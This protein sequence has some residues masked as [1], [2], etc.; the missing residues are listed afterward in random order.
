MFF[1]QLRN[2][3]WKLFGKKRT[4][5][6]FCMFLSAQL[7]LLV[8]F[9]YTNAQRWIV[10]NIRRA[11][12]D[13]DQYLSA[14]TV[15]SFMAAVLAL[16]LIPLYVTLV[17]GDLV[18]KEAEDGT[19]RMILSRPISR[20]RLVFL[21]WV[22]GCIFS[23]ALVLALGAFGLLFSSFWFPLKGGFFMLSIENGVSI[24]DAREGLQHYLL[25][26]AAMVPKACAVMSLAL[27]FSCFN[28]K[29]AAATILSLSLVLI[30][31][32]LRDIPYFA[33]FKHWFLSYYLNVWIELF[34]ARIAWWHVGECLSVM[35]AFSLTC[36]VIGITAFQV[37]DIKS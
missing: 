10:G 13:P 15:A 35:A 29:P 12:F 26:H 33:D 9:R 18:S 3:L 14:L 21:K 34:S 27:M 23:F 36:L 1:L 37:R 17:G 19:L 30:D 25:A 6:G 7:L 31:R 2:E 28:M 16:S 4:Y 11:G 5:I 22:A 24:M 20:I 32:I 8:L